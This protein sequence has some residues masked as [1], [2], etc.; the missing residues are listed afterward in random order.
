MITENVFEKC[1][2]AVKTFLEYVKKYNDDWKKYSAAKKLVEKY[3]ISS[4]ERV[5]R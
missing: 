5:A 3:L 1:R 4:D 2:K